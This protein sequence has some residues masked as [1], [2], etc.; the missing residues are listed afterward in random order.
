MLLP[1]GTSDRMTEHEDSSPEFKML[2]ERYDV[3]KELSSQ[4]KSTLV[5]ER[6]FRFFICTQCH[7]IFETTSCND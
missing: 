3:L 1:G 5:N 4:G 2:Q 6:Y 7:Y